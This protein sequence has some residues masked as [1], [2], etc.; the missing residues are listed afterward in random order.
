MTHIAIIGATRED[1]AFFNHELTDIKPAFYPELATAGDIDSATEVLS[2][3]VDTPV[4]AEI[5]GGLPDLKLIACRSTGY[6]HIDLEAAKK[7]GVVVANVPTYGGT[8]VAEYTFTLLLMLSRQMVEVLRESGKTA[9]NRQRERGTDLFGKTIGI[10]GTGSIG[11]GVARIARGFGMKVLGYDLYPRPEKAEEFGFTYCNDIADLLAQ[12]DVITLHMPY[13]PENHHF[14]S[15][16]H[17]AKMK[18]GATLI[19]T[20]R[21]EL[22]DTTAL[23]GALRHGHLGGAALDVLEG[24]YLMDPDELIALAV[25]N[26]AA[27]DTLRHAVAMA[28]L[29]HMPNVI[30]TDHN[31]YNTNEAIHRINQTT[32]DNIRNYIAG[33][34]VFTV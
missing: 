18:P 10:V 22:I 6:N 1:K 33:K 16:G 23:V 9:P 25:H 5:I 31:A 14:I 26:D 30:L 7:H 11:L 12:S 27:K 28:A 17:I 3:F 2:V 32:A 34:E 13:T 15:A 19:N 24:E 29:Q 4:T 21:G 20:A 8:T